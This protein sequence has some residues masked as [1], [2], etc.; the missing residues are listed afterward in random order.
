MGAEIVVQERQKAGDEAGKA[1][2]STIEKIQQ[3]L[4]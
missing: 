2:G 4:M 1:S 3:R